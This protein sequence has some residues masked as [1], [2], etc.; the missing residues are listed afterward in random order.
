MPSRSRPTPCDRRACPSSGARHRHSE[1]LAGMQPLAVFGATCQRR[2]RGRTGLSI[3]HGAGPGAAQIYAHAHAAG[4]TPRRVWKQR[5]NKRDHEPGRCDA[6][7]VARELQHHTPAPPG[8]R[9]PSHT[10]QRLA[11]RS[12]GLKGP[13]A[14][15]CSSLLASH[16]PSNGDAAGGTSAACCLPPDMPL[17]IGYVRSIRKELFSQSRDVRSKPLCLRC[18]A[19]QARARQLAAAVDQRQAPKWSV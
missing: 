9:P 1:R 15:V 6:S 3:Q 19:A 18:L 4:P 8:P 11:S 7:C 16:P 17:C 10:R 14:P 5:R 2:L 12:T 13:K